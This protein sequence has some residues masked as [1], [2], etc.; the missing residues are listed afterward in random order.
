[1][2]KRW[3]LFVNLLLLQL[4]L[5]L[6]LAYNYVF[7]SFRIPV[8]IVLFAIIAVMISS[9]WVVREMLRLVE[10][11]S[12]AEKVMVRLEEAEKLITTLRSKHH[13]FVN[14]L[15]VILGLIQLKMDNDAADYIKGLSKDLI[16]IEKLVSLKR[17]E[18]AALISSKLA[19][20]SYLQ[21]S[22]DINTTLAELSIPPEKLV[23]ILGNLLDNAIY[24]TS[25]Y[26]DKW[27]KIRID[28]EDEWFIFEITNPG[29]IA[30]EIR[31]RIF[32]PGFTTK[33]QE[34]TGMGL[35][36]VK[37]LVRECGGTISFDSRD[38]D[39][40]TVFT[41]RLPKTSMEHGN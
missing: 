41:V 8:T 35:F 32:E 16:Q 40:M 7:T 36:I 12:E 18:V 33:G 28:Q 31:E 34:G 3:L 39:I 22:L 4:F 2:E 29:T 21:A 11:E 1:M 5:F 17:P 24:E 20:L 27:I 14:H 19:S 23:S 13:D 6:L 26:K 38:H 9:L 37:N 15:Q 25:F 30:P 10:R